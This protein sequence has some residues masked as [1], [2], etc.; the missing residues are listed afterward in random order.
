MKDIIMS[1]VLTAAIILS[2]SAIGI[3]VVKQDTKPTTY[4]NLACRSASASQYGCRGGGQGRCGGCARQGTTGDAQ[5]TDM[6][7]LKQSI[8]EYYSGK[9]GD[10]DFE[11]KIKDFGCHQEAYIIKNG[12]PVKRFTINGGTIYEIG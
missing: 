7:N 4:G 10:K 5:P 11:V 2:G 12:Q 6:Q 1:A 3:M 8:S 9:Y